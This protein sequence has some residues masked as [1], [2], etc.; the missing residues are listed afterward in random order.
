[1]FLD[2]SKVHGPNGKV[3][4]RV[5]L[6]TSFREDGKVKHRTLGN[7]SDCSP[8]QIEAVRL[9]L[10]HKEQLTRFLEQGA[11]QPVEPRAAGATPSPCGE[12]SGPFVQGP[13]VGALAVLA[14][15]AGELGI[16]AA[17]GEDR[18]GRLALWQVLARALDQGSRL[19]A[20]RLARDLGAA[21][22]LGLPRFDEDD[23]YENLAWLAAGQQRIEDALFAWRR[24]AQPGCPLFLYDVTSTYLE[25]LHNA[26]AAFGFNRDEKKGKMQITVGLLCDGNGVPLS[27]QAFPGNCADPR[28]VGEQIEKLRGRFA[29]PHVT[30][31]GDRGMLRGPQIGELREAG[32]HHITAITKPQIESLLARGVLQLELFE[33]Q[34]A[35]VL[36]PAGAD[37]PDSPPERY[38]L[39]RNPV[40]R[41]EMER[42]RRDKQSALGR[43]AARLTDHLAQHPRAKQETARKKL[44]ARLRK[45]RLDGWLEVEVAGRRVTLREDPARLAE[46]SKLDGCYVI[47]TDLDAADATAQLVHQRYKDL[48]Q[49]EQAFRRSKTVEL[50][51]RPVHVRTEASTRGHLLVVM[52][53]YLLMQELGKRWAN[54]DV[55]V[56]EG[57][58]RLNTYCAVEVAGVVR[59]MLE[60]RRDVAELLAAARVAIPTVLPKL[61]PPVSTKRKLPERRPSRLK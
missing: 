32:I 39:R 15:L 17:L 40:R 37:G 27:I 10:R 56:A 30:L 8:Q 51:M 13:S 4:Q 28:T 50:Q 38:I 45:L 58:G 14:G 12:P 23:L 5:L 35:E 36:V 55:T 53:A 20:V 60:P 2:C 61:A 6:R 22:V 24:A 16:T 7:L 46:E 44:E 19:S 57:L 31:V 11:S 34:L 54:L 59:L 1:M 9:A 48:A 43:E 52:L 47:R 42:A 26:F 41:Q 21:Q 29:A 33:N 49:V 18:A 25:G 3:Y